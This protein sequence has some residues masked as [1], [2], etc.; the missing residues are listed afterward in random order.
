MN[1]GSDQRLPSA[2]IKEF[3]RG[4]AMLNSFVDSVANSQKDLVLFCCLLGLATK[5]RL[6]FS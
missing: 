5:A 3:R 2:L 6:E 1:T 4:P